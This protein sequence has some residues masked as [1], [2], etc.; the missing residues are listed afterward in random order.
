MS[1]PNFSAVVN[2]LGAGKSYCDGSIV[3]QLPGKVTLFLCLS[4]MAANWQEDK[5]HV[6]QGS[7]VMMS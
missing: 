2:A 7:T 1:L 3:F 5:L 6:A 4:F